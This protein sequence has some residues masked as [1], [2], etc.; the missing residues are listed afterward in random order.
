MFDIKLPENPCSGN[1]ADTCGC[2]DGRTNMT[3]LAEA[4][5]D[6]ANAPKKIAGISTDFSHGSC[7]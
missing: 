3:K 7:S 4:L 5:H 2:K 1:Q 6:C